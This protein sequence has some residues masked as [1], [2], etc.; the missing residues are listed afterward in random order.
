MLSPISA[1]FTMV[2]GGEA[3]TFGDYKVNC[4]EKDPDAT[5]GWAAN[6]DTFNTYTP[7]GLFSASYV[8]CPQWLAEALTEEFG[9]TVTPGWYNQNDEEF[10]ENK[11][12][13]NVPF[14]NG[15]VAKSFVSGAKV[16]FAGAVKPTPTV[17]DIGAFTVAGNVSPATISIGQIVVNCDEEDPDATTGWAANGDGIYTY[18]DVGLFKA[19]YIY[20]PKWLAEA[21]TVDFG[22][23]VK[24]GWYDQADEAFTN[25]VN[26]SLTFAA[27]E[28]FIA[29]SYVTGAT[30]T[31]RSA[32][33][34]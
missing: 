6:G 9:Y 18:T 11:S 22:Y 2:D 19:A 8:Y 3:F 5:T 17:T 10:K 27:G 14:G 20:C 33:A 26:E 21:L 34:Q 13:T 12:G 30:L 23:Q 31:I 32:I 29:K 1:T 24:A 7:V 4:D 16:T 28:G 25:C 15:V